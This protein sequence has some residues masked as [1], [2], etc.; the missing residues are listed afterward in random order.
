MIIAAFAILLLQDSRECLRRAEACVQKQDHAG[1]VDWYS[2]AIEADPDCVDAYFGRAGAHGRLNKWA[3]A[4]DDYS[5]TLDL[6]PGRAAA[7]RERGRA[8]LILKNYKDAER[9]TK[10]ATEVDP[11][12]GESFYMHGLVFLNQDLFDKA[13][14]IFTTCIELFAGKPAQNAYLNRGVCRENLDRLDEALKDFD[15]TVRQGPKNHLGHWGR[16]RVLADLGKWA[17]A[18]DAYTRAIEISPKHESSLIGRGRCQLELEK[19]DAAIADFNAVLKLNPKSANALAMRAI[20]RI[21]LGE[22]GAA[23][24]DLAAAKAIQWTDAVRWGLGLLHQRQGKI[25]EAYDAMKSMAADRRIWTVACYTFLNLARQL[26]P[27]R[28][29][30]A[31]ELKALDRLLAWSP[32]DTLVRLW[33]GQVRLLEGAL[34][35]AEEDF[36]KVLESTDD[37]EKVVAACKGRAT[38]RLWTGRYAAALKDADVA[39]DWAPK[40][41]DAP[42]LRIRAL[43]GQGKKTPAEEALRDVLD[44]TPGRLDALWILAD[45]QEKDADR[46]AAAETLSRIARNVA[47]G[48]SP[49]ELEA[50]IPKKDRSGTIGS[51]IRERLA[52][53]LVVLDRHRDA[54][55]ILEELVKEQ[56]TWGFRRAK[57]AETLEQLG[58]LEGA[59]KTWDDAMKVEEVAKDPGFRTQRG[60]WHYRTD[61]L[62]EARKDYEVGF[63]GREYFA[64]EAFRKWAI[65]TIRTA[66]PRTAALNLR[67][68]FDAAAKAATKWGPDDWTRGLVDYFTNRRAVTDDLLRLAELQARKGIEEFER[69]VKEAR[70]AEELEEARTLLEAAR[71]QLKE[72]IRNWKAEAMYVLGMQCLGAGKTDDARGW[73]EKSGTAEAKLELGRLD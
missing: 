53:L 21:Q 59:Q 65:L 71:E 17:D 40:D 7:W 3:A 55:P 13:E 27:S 14:P 20:V 6:D 1:A 63:Q 66:D 9:D 73:F 22:H 28:R 68:T 44:E 16:A 58:D 56:P 64:D 61:R 39:I 41:P 45:L 4:R 5:K 32:K 8:H 69:R 15:E 12:D 23:E 36:T 37:E 10:R 62:A 35:G 42:M 70:S 34:E 51:R 19:R 49:E 24:Q 46:A 2:K 18:R 54:L 57:L 30:L 43:L 38:V 31:S 33:R 50:L 72:S 48:E 47:I 52:R 60:A 67:R 11:E 25:A 29:A 26:P